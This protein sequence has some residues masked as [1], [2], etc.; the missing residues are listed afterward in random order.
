MLGKRTQLLGLAFCLRVDEG[1]A[2]GVELGEL[3]GKGQD[4]RQDEDNVY[5]RLSETLWKIGREDEARSA[6]E[7]G[8]EQAEKFGHPGM[9]EDLRLA[10]SGLGK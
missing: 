7:K 2:G 6:Q 10:A 1:G 8:I 4:L 5:L 9:A 3:E